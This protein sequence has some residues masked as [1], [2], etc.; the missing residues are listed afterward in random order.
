MGYP[1]RCFNRIKKRDNPEGRLVRSIIIYLRARGFE[2][3]KIKT[4]GV[5]DKVSR[6][7]R[8]DLNAWT[9]VPDI[10]AFC[11]QLVFIEA[12]SA[13]GTQSEHQ[14]KFQQLCLVANIPYILARSLQDIEHLV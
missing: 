8:L 10:L 1:R 2:A 5:Y 12:K 11:P 3:A 6:A 13:T 4:H 9:G 7:Y 14:K